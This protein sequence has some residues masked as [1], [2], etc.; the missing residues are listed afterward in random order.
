VVFHSDLELEDNLDLFVYGLVFSLSIYSTLGHAI[1][2]S[3]KSIVG[4]VVVLV[5]L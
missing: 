4:G 2:T 1:T 5:V 3:F